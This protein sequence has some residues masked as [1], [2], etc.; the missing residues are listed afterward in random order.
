MGGSRK[1]N[2]DEGDCLKGRAWLV[3]RFKGVGVFKKG[4]GPN[5]HYGLAMVT[6]GNKINS[7]L[8]LASPVKMIKHKQEQFR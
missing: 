5:A 2:I 4:G 1:T 3:C 6:P 7:K 8:L